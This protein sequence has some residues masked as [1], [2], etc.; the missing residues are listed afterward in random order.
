MTNHTVDRKHRSPAILVGIG[1]LLIAGGMLAWFRGAR[2]GVPGKLVTREDLLTWQGPSEALG[3]TQSLGEANAKFEVENVGGA[4]VRILG[5]ETTCGCATPKIQPSIIAPGGTGTVEVQ[6]V[7]LQIGEKTV[8]VT[9]KTDSPT[10]PELVLRLRIVGNRRPPFLGKAGGDLSYEGTFDSPQARDII[11]YNV[12]LDGSVP[13]PPGVETT[14]PILE[15]GPPI[16]AEEKPYIDPG[17]VY[18]KYIYKAEIAANPPQ[19]QFGGDVF[20]ID[21]WLPQHRERILV[22]GEVSPPLRAVPPRIILRVRRAGGSVEGNAKLMILSSTPAPDLVA[23]LDGDEAVPLAIR[24]VEMAESDH[25]ALISISPKP[26]VIR[27]GEYKLLIGR[28][29]SARERI[30]VPVS[31]RFENGS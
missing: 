21:P 11:A 26:G 10:T 9:L 2:S 22:H 17:T 31:L 20:I 13:T 4:P 6:A 29:S 7:P 24:L 3:R 15:I 1:L 27:E 19:G 23:E 16:L 25:K 14:L 18:R 12:E 28:R 5:V 8:S 30:T